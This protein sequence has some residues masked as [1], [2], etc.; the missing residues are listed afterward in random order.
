MQQG[1]VIH[2]PHDL[3][4][5]QLDSGELQPQQLKVKVKAGG[6]CGSDLHYYHHGGFG[7]VRI[8]E[9]MVLGHEAA[10]EV[11]QVG[12]DTEGFAVGDQVV[13]SFVPSCG[14][15]APCASGRAAL[16]EPGAKTNTAGSLLSGARR[17]HQN[18]T[19]ELHHHLGVSAFAEMTVVSARS[20]VR[21]DRD[22]V[23]IGPRELDELHE[24]LLRS[25]KGAPGRHATPAH[26]RS[27]RFH[28]PMVRNRLHRSSYQDS[29]RGRAGLR[30]RARDSSSRGRLPFAGAGESASD[31]AVCHA[32]VS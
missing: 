28:R 9:P 17:W 15:C 1:L 6:I 25:S 29:A 30:A 21:V 18:D 14:H 7:V 12:V 32:A 19:S 10:G 3:R 31:S 16:C 4:I 26:Q 22:L 5:Q 24:I 13:F 8:K 23:S 20:A 2:A 11:V 27:Q